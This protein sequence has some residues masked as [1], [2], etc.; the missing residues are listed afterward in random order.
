MKETSL[1][2]SLLP[3]LA[4]ERG[5]FYLRFQPADLRMSDIPYHVSPF[6]II[7][8][9]D[10]FARI[11]RAAFVTDYGSTIKE[12]N[13]LFQRDVVRLSTEKEPVFINPFIDRIWQQAG[14]M[15]QNR[16]LDHSMLLSLQVSEQGQLLAFSPL[17]FCTLNSVFIEPPCPECGHPLQLCTNDDLL[18]SSGIPLYSESLR[19]YLHCP[20][21]FESNNQQTWYTLK[22]STDDPKTVQSSSQLISS[23]DRLESSS[24]QNADFPCFTCQQK[25]LCYGHEQK[26]HD[27]IFILSFYPF[28][29]LITERDSLE[30]FHFLTMAL[31]NQPASIDVE[32]Y[33]VELSGEKADTIHELK[34]STPDPAI[35]ILLKNISE[36]WQNKSQQQTP[37]YQSIS[38]HGFEKANLPVDEVNGKD[39]LDTETVIIS[40]SNQVHSEG[41]DTSLD[42]TVLISGDSTLNIHASA[43]LHPVKGGKESKPLDLEDDLEKTVILKPG[44]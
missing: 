19:R 18:N 17:F 33:S 6:A 7:D 23:F 16:S 20:S 30:G 44:E 37:P 26:V 24:G 5:G 2:P 8:D 12:V 39:D 38:S 34:Q 36:K 29:M 4:P 42:D 13:L 14:A 40:S 1:Q 43:D 41:C 21:C 3:Y 35:S 22:R 9:Q 15:R 28:Y 31:D 25:K 11:Y 32:S 10:S 27:T